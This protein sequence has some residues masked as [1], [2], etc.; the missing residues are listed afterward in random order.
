M[1][2]FYDYLEEK[3]EEA[4]EKELLTEDAST[5]VAAALGLPVL[6]AVAVWGASIILISYFGLLNKLITSIVRMWRKMFKDTRIV[7]DRNKVEETIRKMN[8]DSRVA[9]FKKE[10][11]KDRRIFKEELGIIYAAIEKK[12]IDEAAKLF[13]E[14]SKDLKNNPDI[15][16]VIISELAKTFNEPPLY[17]TS[18]GNKTYQAIKKI[19]NIRVA[20]ASA[21][22]TK[23]AI[24]KR[25]AED[26][27]KTLEK[28]V[29]DES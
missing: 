23:L 28:E 1:K 2:T 29:E 13:N 17:V 11:E 12:D 25:L 16:R 21:M 14:L 24:E 15:H 4:F 20:R 22:A 19:I 8:S 3:E 18:P 26:T 10:M 9:E 5:V 27:V 6:T 7:F